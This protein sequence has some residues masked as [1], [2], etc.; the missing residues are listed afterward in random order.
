MPAG[1]AWEIDLFREP[2]N[3]AI[4]FVQPYTGELSLNF[5]NVPCGR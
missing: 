1:P 2:R 4:A 3:W 5:C